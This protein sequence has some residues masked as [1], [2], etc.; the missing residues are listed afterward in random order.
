LTNPVVVFEILSPSTE[1]YDRRDK[2]EKYRAIET[3]KEY[4]LVSQDRV[5]VE[6]FVRQPS[7]E[8]LYSSFNHLDDVLTLASAPATLKLRDI[9]KRVFPP[10]DE[11]PQ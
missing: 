4:V 6:R 5:L 2:F 11:D 7:G 8:W 9:Y 10:Q 3:L 1:M